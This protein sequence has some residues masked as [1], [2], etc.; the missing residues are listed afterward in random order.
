MSEVTITNDSAISATITND[1]LNTGDVTFG[2]KGGTFGDPT[3][4]E[5]SGTTSDTFGS[6][7]LSLAKESANEVS[8]SNDS[9]V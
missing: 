1:G 6:P 4:A 7:G 2:T 8:I 9:I 5:T 3:S